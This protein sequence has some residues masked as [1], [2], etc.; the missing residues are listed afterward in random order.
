M[1]WVAPFPTTIIKKL[2]PNKAHGHDKISI[3]MLKLYGDSI[4]RP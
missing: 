4:N 1:Y 2:D 3:R